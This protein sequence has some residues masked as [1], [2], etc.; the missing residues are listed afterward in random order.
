M[1][2]P[3]HIS[4][5][6]ISRVP[7]RYSRTLAVLLAVQAA[8]IGQGAGITG[9][10]RLLDSHDPVVQKHN[11]YSGVVI[12]LERR[13]G[14]TVPVVPKAAQMAQQKKHFVPPVL[15]VPAGS[16]VSFPNFDPIFHNAFSNFAGQIF[17]VG[18]YPPR[19]DQRVRFRQ[20]GIVRVFCN[21]HPTMS[22]VIVVLNT[23]YLAVSNPS[24]SF[25][26]DGVQPGEYQ[27]S[28]FHERATEETLKALSRS[29]TIGDEAVA[30]PQLAILETGYIPAPH[31]NKYGQE[32]P[33]VIED[34]P[35]YPA[36]R[37]R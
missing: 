7:A 26:I 19:T 3:W 33:A 15:A 1:T 36:G 12:W 9:S 37:S 35:M 30:L 4:S 14:T 5:E 8:G 29:L 11:D 25:R 21:I 31:K 18:L 22:G 32:Y 20:P 23:P 34:R 2:W 16:T 10:V 24:G 27:L 13:D 28:V 17:D 6:P